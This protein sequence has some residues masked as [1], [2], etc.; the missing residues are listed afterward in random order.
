MRTRF[1]FRLRTLMIAVTLF[2]V[3]VGGY[4]G[5]QAKI[6]RARRA[7][8]S[9]NRQKLTEGSCTEYARENPAARPSWI[10]LWLGDESYGEICAQPGVIKEAAALFPEAQI[11]EIHMGDPFAWPRAVSD[12]EESGL[13]TSDDKRK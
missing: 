9:S 1:Q 11:L 8:L 7:W 10:R 13:S 3:V 4:I 12:K 2:C 5:W 6:V